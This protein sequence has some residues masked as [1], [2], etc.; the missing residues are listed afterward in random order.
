MNY[1]ETLE[2]IHSVSWKGSRPGLERT[3]ER[4]Y[5]MKNP[6]KKLKFVHIA[7]TNGKGS[8]ASMTANILEK[9][10]YT[11]GLYTSP[12]IFSF[13]ER[14]RVNG[15]NISDSDLVSVTEFVKPLAEK[16]TD[17]PTEFEL[18]TCIAF[19]YFYRKKCDIVVLEV[20][21]GGELDSTNVIEPP[22]VSVITNIGLDHTDFLGDT[23]EKIAETKSKIIKENSIAVLYPSTKGVEEV[24][25]KR[26]HDVNSRLIKADFDA[27]IS[28][29]KSLS[30]QTFDYKGLK[31]VKLPLLGKHQ[32]NNTATVFAVIDGLRSKGWNISDT[33]V[34]EGIESVRWQGRFELVSESPTFI[35][36]GGHNPQCAA[37][38]FE[39]VKSY[40]GG[41]KLVV[42]TGVLAD[43]DFESMYAD[44]AT[45]TSE[46]VTVTPPNPRALSAEKLAEYLTRFGKTATPCKTIDEGVRLAKEK[47]GEKGA[48]LAYGSLYMV[49]DIENAA[50]S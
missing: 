16:M 18:V 36:D 32:L 31:N 7:G 43:K 1:N 27:V 6:E 38:L 49:A 28:K 19:E 26:C 41:K 33:A 29:E 30:G 39:N 24:V 21:M 5:L 23:L 17:S 46:F 50:R 37:S 3:R 20:G 12:Y 14:M 45:L 35:V 9:A 25:E 8:T 4:L 44:M 10:G 48:V 40:L 22:E 42:L 34:R 13:N 47:A 2:Y 11:V 15:E